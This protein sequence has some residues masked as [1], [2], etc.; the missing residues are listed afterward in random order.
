MNEYGELGDSSA[1]ILGGA[2]AGLSTSMIIV[3]LIIYVLQVIAMWK[4]FTKAGEEGWKSLIPIYNTIVLFKISGINPLL[5][6]VYLAGA[7]PFVGGLA[8]LGITIYQAIN[9]AKTFGKT[10]GFAAGLIL[11][12]PVFYM[13]LGFGSDQYVGVQKVEATTTNTDTTKDAK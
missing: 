8:V 6:L 10:G 7:I 4:I 3:S 5:V 1:A 12:P 2:I 13:I 9:L 11:L